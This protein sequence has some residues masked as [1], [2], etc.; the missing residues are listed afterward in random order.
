MHFEP[1]Y[2]CMSREEIAQLQLERLQS[3]LFRLS[4]NV[5]FYRR[6]FRELDFD[7]EELRSLEDLSKLPFTTKADLRDNYPYG[8]FAVP[9]REV[10]RLHSSSGTTGKSVVVGYTRNDV[11]RWA[12][13]AAR[14]LTAG[15]VTRDDVVQIAFNYGLFTG[16]FG[17]HYGAEL[18]GASVIPS[19]SGN[20]RRQ[21]QIMQDYKTT[22]LLC[23]PSYALHLAGS[24][25]EAGVN[26]NALDLKW[27]LFGAE[28]WSETM[29]AEIQERLKITATDNYGL[30]EIMGPG[31]ASECLERAGLHV[32]ED[33]FLAE[34]VDPETLTPAP[35]GEKGEL[36]LTTLTKEA[37]PMLRFRTGDLTRLIPGACACG[38]TFLRMDRI[39]GRADD[40]FT[41]RGVNVFPAQVEAALLTVPG[42]EPCYQIVI[43]REGALDTATVLVEASTEECFDEIRKHQQMV[44]A[45]AKTLES[46]V[47]ASFAV[48][49]VEKSSLYAGDACKA[50][51]VVDNRKF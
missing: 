39:L 30:T 29:R 2:E 36:V 28:C 10:V 48:K 43:E 4:R 16:G 26:P 9:L 25:E 3:T 21:I 7:P 20:T 19:S 5:P 44:L 49:L 51:R 45:I 22:A 42:I 18:L 14:V 50:K 35:L 46:N 17:F 1:E 8:M 37:F 27:G 6:K 13:L 47:G 31:V 33:H 15:G 11:K 23:T 24:M 40:M 32:N 38:R 12:K 41:L 34:V